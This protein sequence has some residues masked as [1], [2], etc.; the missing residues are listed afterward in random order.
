MLLLWPYWSGQHWYQLHI[1]H[2]KYKLRKN[3]R[4]PY[5][6]Y[7]PTGTLVMFLW[8]SSSALDIFN[9]ESWIMKVLISPSV[10]CSVSVDISIGQSQWWPSCISYHHWTQYILLPLP[11]QKLE[12]SYIERYHTIHTIIS[13]APSKTHYNIIKYLLQWYNFNI[14]IGYNWDRLCWDHKLFLTFE[15]SIKMKYL[16]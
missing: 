3:V 8:N 7:L 5:W 6:N 16:Y 11:A 1:G 12:Q 10:R 9:N 4:K 14:Y 2:I 13:A 15:T